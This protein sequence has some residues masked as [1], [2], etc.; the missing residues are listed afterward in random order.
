MKTHTDK[1]QNTWSQSVAKNPSQK[2]NNAKPA[3]LIEDQR[4]DSSQLQNIKDVVDNANDHPRPIQKKSNKTGLPDNLKAG[5][6]NLS[7][8]SM[9]DVK[10]HYNSAKP[11]GL[12]AHAY[13][14]GSQIHLAPGQEKHLPHE[15]WHVVQQKQGRVKPTLQMKGK[16]QY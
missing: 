3:F 14:Q 9:D 12:Q 4:H 1:S 8:L 11:A 15:A 13:A 2:S 6:E 16:D 5:I 7:G 10:V